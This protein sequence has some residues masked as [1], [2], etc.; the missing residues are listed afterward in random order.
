MAAVVTKLHGLRA[1]IQTGRPRS[2]DTLTGRGAVATIS[3]M[4]LGIKPCP[5]AADS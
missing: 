2:H 4:R 1:A 3:T 5:A